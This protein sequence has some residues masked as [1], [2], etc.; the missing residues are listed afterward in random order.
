MAVTRSGKRT[1]ANSRRNASW[2][3]LPENIQRIIFQKAA[4]G[5]M[6]ARKVGAISK[7]ARNATKYKRAAGRINKAR[8]A[9]ITAGDTRGEYLH[10]NIPHRLGRMAER[11]GNNQGIGSQYRIRENIKKNFRNRILPKGPTNINNSQIRYYENNRYTYMLNQNGILRRKV[12]HVNPGA[13]RYV[14][15]IGKV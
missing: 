3:N 1:G 14:Q 12:T 6:Q 11:M 5:P 2:N 8:W 13:A 10:N 9:Y 4:S 7:L 15:Y